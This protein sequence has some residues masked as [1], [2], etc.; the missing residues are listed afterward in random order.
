MKEEN[1]NHLI[2]KKAYKNHD[3]LFGKLVGVVEKSNSG[4]SPLCIV[5]PSGMKLGAFPKD[6]VVIEDE[7]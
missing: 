1:Y 4:I 2:G 3:G 7:E 5:L 6:L